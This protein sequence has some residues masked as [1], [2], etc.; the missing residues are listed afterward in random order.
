MIVEDPA[1]NPSVQS[2]R[3]LDLSKFFLTILENAAKV[4]KF[5]YDFCRLS[6]DADVDVRCYLSRYR[7]NEYLRLFSIDQR[8]CRSRY[9]VYR[10]LEVDDTLIRS[11]MILSIL[12]FLHA[13]DETLCAGMMSAEFEESAVVSVSDINTRAASWGSC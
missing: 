1:R 3:R 2:M 13:C 6:V 11:C 7:L 10:S 5:I 4:R 8:V 9:T 12:K